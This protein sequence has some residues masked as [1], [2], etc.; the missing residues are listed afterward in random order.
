MGEIWTHQVTLLYP[1]TD[2]LIGV[3]TQRATV[4]AVSTEQSEVEWA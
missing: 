4:Q 2:V 3:L 1:I